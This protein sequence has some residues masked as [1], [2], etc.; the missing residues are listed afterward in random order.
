VA[1]YDIVFAYDM[2]AGVIQLPVSGQPTDVQVGYG[3]GG[4][5]NPVPCEIIQ[6]NAPVMAVTATFRARRVGLPIPLPDWRPPSQ[7]S[8][9]TL[10]RVRFA[11]KDPALNNSDG[12][13]YTF[14]AEGFVE[15]LLVLPFTPSDGF[16]MGAAPYQTLPTNVVGITADQFN[17]TIF[18]L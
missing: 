9:Y 13:T 8:K 3:K 4:G 10:K 11:A 18:P 7:S 14:S 5:I 17:Q 6:M 15:Y 16:P 1:V 12:Q 2:D